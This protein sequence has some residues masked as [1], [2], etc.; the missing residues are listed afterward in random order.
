MWYAHTEEYY[1]TTRSY[2]LTHATEGMNIKNSML[3]ERSQTQKDTC[4]MI[5][6]VWIV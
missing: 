4:C 5:L 6:S 3:C 1:S 2:I